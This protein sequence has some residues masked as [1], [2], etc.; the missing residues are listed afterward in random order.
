M[1]SEKMEIGW[2]RYSDEVT[3]SGG[4][5]D[6][7]YPLSNLTDQVNLGRPARSADL[8]AASLV[9]K[10]TLPRKRPIGLIGLVGHNLTTAAKV[11]VIGY[12]DAAWTTQAFDTGAK[13]IWPTVSG[14][15][16][17]WEDDNWWSRTYESDAIKGVQALGLIRLSDKPFVQSFDINITDAGNPDGKVRIRLLELARGEQMPV[18]FEFGAD[19]G[20]RS[21]TLEQEADGAAEYFERR[22][23][24]RV[25]NGRV[26]LLPRSVS[27]GVIYELQKIADINIGFLFIRNPA[28]NSNWHREA[29]LVRNVS[30][31]PLRQVFAGRDTWEFSFKERI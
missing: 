28:D 19:V 27:M 22:A 30:L 6:A 18:N 26:P 12:S 25:F 24:P 3:L 2:P 8:D 23:K 14:I 7:G 17:E 16:P 20:W 15:N 29:A 31:S 11:Q 9:I 21:R 4:S 1:T 13:F 5:W 10:G